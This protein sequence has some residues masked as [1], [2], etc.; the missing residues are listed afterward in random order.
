MHM[1]L[2]MVQLIDSCR[3]GIAAGSPIPIPLMKTLVE[4]LNLTD[5]TIAY[6]MSAYIFFIPRLDSSNI[7]V[8]AA[9]TRYTV[10]VWDK[11][12]K[13]ADKMCNKAQSLFKRLPMTH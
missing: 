6:G 11:L 10:H 8:Y 9:E 2:R 4:K 3:T 7:V 5:L 1:I 13:K 12:W